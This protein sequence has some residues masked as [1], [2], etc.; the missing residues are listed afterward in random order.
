M[1]PGI[2]FSHEQRMGL[3][4]VHNQLGHDLLLSALLALSNSGITSQTATLSLMHAVCSPFF[5][6]AANSTG[7][8]WYRANTEDL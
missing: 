4:G 3:L 8:A 7:S 6:L 2:V 1:N 5:L